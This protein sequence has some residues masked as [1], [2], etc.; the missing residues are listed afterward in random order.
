MLL[1]SLLPKGRTHQKSRLDLVSLVVSAYNEEEIIERKIMNCL[2]L[3][4]PK[5]KLEIIIGSDGS[6]DKTDEII[7]R[8]SQEGVRLYRFNQRQGKVNVL[9]K[10]IYKTRGRI[11]V[12]SDANTIFKPSAVK[13][14]V[15][16]FIDPRIGCVC[17]K[18]ILQRANSSF[19]GKIEGIYWRYES[20]LKR[21]EGRMGSLLGAN[22][23]I[24]A[25][26]KELFN[27]LPSNTIV[28]DFVIP[29]KILQ[30]GYKVIY[31][32][33]AIAF[34]KSAKGISEQRIRK[35]RIG[36]GN[37]QALLL[38]LPLLNIFRGFPSLAYWSHKVIRWFVP[39][40]LILLLIFNILLMKENFFQI[41]FI[42]QAC[43]YAGAAIGYFLSENNYQIRLFVLMYY[44]I[45]VNW[46]LLMGFFKFIAGTQ[47]VTW[48]KVNR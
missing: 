22:G 21:L 36:A 3:D 20:F 5:D 25:I 4:Y 42:L 7:K 16:H 40:L 8:Y 44:F 23:G 46:S 10:L 31:A 45:S 14:L 33:L 39:F 41:I 19:E 47:K 24:Y 32:P 29:M 26:R 11:I 2:E 12:F 34:E 38:T 43:F 27:P 6:T 17:G 37:Y 30:K 15:K 48:Q 35:T 9:N 28:E 1:S 18:L 13:E